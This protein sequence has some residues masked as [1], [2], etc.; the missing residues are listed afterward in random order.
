MR[1]ELPLQHF[2]QPVFADVL[3]LAWLFHG[4]CLQH[5]SNYWQFYTFHLHKIIC[6]CIVHVF[7]QHLVVWET[8]T[9]CT[10]SLITVLTT[11]RTSLWFRSHRCHTKKLFMHFSCNRCLWPKLKI[12]K[13]QVEEKLVI[14]LLQYVWTNFCTLFPD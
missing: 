11:V 9:I 7:Q 10:G 3:A 13:L 8:L 6:T 4:H 14:W 12:M 1:R 2:W 5:H